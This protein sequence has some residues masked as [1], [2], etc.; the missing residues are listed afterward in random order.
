MRRGA[1]PVDGR[2]VKPIRHALAFAVLLAALVEEA[3]ASA[4]KYE[5]RL[6]V[7]HGDDFADRESTTRFA[8]VQG[9]LRHR[10]LPTRT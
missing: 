4:A 5:G 2:C 3:P 6:E 1:A 10:L 9:Q 7:R 8:L